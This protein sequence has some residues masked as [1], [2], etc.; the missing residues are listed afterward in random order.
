VVVTASLERTGYPP[1][2][3]RPMCRGTSSPRRNEAAVVGEAPPALGAAGDG[4]AEVVTASSGTGRVPSRPKSTTVSRDEQSQA[5]RCCG[6]RRGAPCYPWP[7]PT[8]VSRDWVPCAT[9][10]RQ[11]ARRPP[12][13]GAAED[14]EA[15][16]VTASFGTGRVPPRPRP[17]AVSRDEQSQAQRCGCCRR[18]A[19]RARRGGGRG[20][21]GSRGEPW[22][23]PGTPPA[24]ADHCVARRAVP[25]ATVRR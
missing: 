15:V 4:E 22:D 20:S 6:S 8:T 7:R 17:T 14:E 21:S 19:P 10:L 9:V 12:V 24:Q 3:G 25:G 11:S 1:G 5:Q 2:P 23:G 18:G 16:V 13:L